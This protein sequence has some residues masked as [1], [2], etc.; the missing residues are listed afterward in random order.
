MTESSVDPRL[1][2]NGGQPVRT[3]VWPAWPRVDALAQRNVLDVLHS[4][5]W[6][7]SGLS[8]RTNSYERRFGEEFAAYI[9]AAFGVPCSSGTAA[10]TIAL[11]AL[12][13]APGDEVI[14]PGLTW[15]ACASSVCNLGAIPILV[16]IDPLTFCLSP[17]AVQ[18]ALTPR[19]RAIMAVHLYSSF[20]DVD[21]LQRIANDYGIPI[22]EDCSQ[23]HGAMFNG[24]RAGRFGRV[25]A[26]SLQQS[27]LLT[28]GEGG[29]AVT[30]DESLYYLMQQFRA[31]GRYYRRNSPDAQ[32]NFWELEYAG[33]VAGRNL[34]MNEL[35]AAV[36]LGNLSHLDVQNDLRAHNFRI[37]RSKVEGSALTFAETSDRCDRPTFYRLCG[38]IDR[39]AIRGRSM[40]EIAHALTAEL[41]LPVEPIDR[42]LNDHPLYQPLQSS[43]ISSSAHAARIDPKRFRLPVATEAA[44]TCVGFPHQCLLG[45]ESDLD[46]IARAIRRVLA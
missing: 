4:T 37:L 1:A 15:V 27:K 11:Q 8:E 16:D 42:P 26:F 41:R 6:A 22:L 24:K 28:A 12:G 44:E 13:I 36:V 10:L 21:A 45:D 34:C 31:D 46:D 29:I 32:W 40:E 9:G 14:V 3:R 2:V 38:R 17:D 20:A 25:A 39:H 5:K 35:C 18:V 33:D 30:D 43:Q 23:A 19:T 7:I